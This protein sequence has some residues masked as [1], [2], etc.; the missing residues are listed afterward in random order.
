ML[1][2][3]EQ[4]HRSSSAPRRVRNHPFARLHLLPRLYVRLANEW[5]LRPLRRAGAGVLYFLRLRKLGRIG[6]MY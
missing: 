6:R 5:P 1:C 4:R 2:F 3:T